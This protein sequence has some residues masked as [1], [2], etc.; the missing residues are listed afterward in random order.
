MTLSAPELLAAIGALIT[1]LLA[2]AKWLESRRDAAEAIAKDEQQQFANTLRDV[3]ESSIRVVM[4]QNYE[5]Q[6]RVENLEGRIDEMDKQHA[7]QMAAKDET[8][9]KLRDKITALQTEYAAAAAKAEAQR[10]YLVDQINELRAL[11]GDRRS[12]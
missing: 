10:E 2:V 5:L 1:A 12:H 4:E 6:R 7:A 8:I 9:E 11:A 3:Q